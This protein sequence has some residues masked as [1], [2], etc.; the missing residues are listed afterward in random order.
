MKEKDEDRG[1]DVH[2]KTQPPRAE[3]MNTEQTSLVPLHITTKLAAASAAAIRTSSLHKTQWPS[4][5]CSNFIRF[6]LVHRYTTD[7]WQYIKGRQIFLK[8]QIRIILLNYLY[9][10]RNQ[11]IFEYFKL[12][13][14]I[15]HNQMLKCGYCSLSAKQSTSEQQKKFRSNAGTR[16]VM[17]S[18]LGFAAKPYMTTSDISC[19]LSVFLALVMYQFYVL[20]YNL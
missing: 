3:E 14:Q 5:R 4:Q 7:I 16:W 19:S 13:N 11:S 2:A 15:F 17:Q 8:F 18:V 6:N 1:Q 10:K 20:S 12:T 9:L